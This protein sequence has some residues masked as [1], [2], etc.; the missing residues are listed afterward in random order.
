VIAGKL[1]DSVVQRLE[2]AGEKGMTRTA[3][4]KGL[5]PV[6]AAGEALAIL[7]AEEEVVEIGATLFAKRHAPDLA[8]LAV[9]IRLILLKRPTHCLTAAQIKKLATKETARWIQPAL[10]KMRLKQEVIELKAGSSRLYVH[11]DAAAGWFSTAKPETIPVNGSAVLE[12]VVGAYKTLIETRGGFRTVPISELKAALKIELDTLHHVIRSE[13]QRRRANIY[14]SS[15]AVT[16]QS[17]LDAAMWL[18]NDSEAYVSV[19][20]YD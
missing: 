10:E 4:L 15:S 5:R 20:F 1:A 14:R 7:L 17:M 19:E 18:N 6:K 11:R 2:G 9:A 8:K 16:P 13:I 12:K 3:L